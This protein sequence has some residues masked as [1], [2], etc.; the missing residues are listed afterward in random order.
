MLL[1]AYYHIDAGYF[2]FNKINGQLVLYYIYCYCVVN[3]HVVTIPTIQ[4][5]NSKQGH[6]QLDILLGI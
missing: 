2:H 3:M 5:L 6:S 4:G 1:Y